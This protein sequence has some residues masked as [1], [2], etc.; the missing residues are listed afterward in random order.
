MNAI[1]NTPSQFLAQKEA[2]QTAAPGKSEQ[3][4]E[5]AKTAAATGDFK[6]AVD[7]RT[8]S[9]NAVKN[10]PSAERARA[11]AKK[12][13]VAPIPPQ[14]RAPNRPTGNLLDISA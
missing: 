2:A 8:Q 11:E 4:S 6:A 12:S 5:A 1:S 14:A 13:G 10:A 9:I 3:L 7:P